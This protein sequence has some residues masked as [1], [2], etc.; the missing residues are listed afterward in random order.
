VSTS[1]SQ[2]AHL[3]FGVFE[4]DLKTGELRRAGVRIKL[5][6]QPFKA[7]ALLAS[8]P[9]EMVSR[10]ELYQHIWGDTIVEEQ[11]LNF[12]IKQIRDALGDD[13]DSPRFI[14]TL[15]KRGYRFLVPVEGLPKSVEA[16][17]PEPAPAH[18]GPRISR[19]AWL[20]GLVVLLAAGLYVVRDRIPGWRGR[21][22]EGKVMLLVLPFDNLSGDPAQEYF[23]DGLT[24]EMI[25]QLGRLNPDRLGVIARNTAMIYKGTKKS[26]AEIGREQEVE[27]ILEGSVRRAGGRVRISAQLIEVRDQTHLWAENYD[28]AVEDVLAIQSDVARHIAGALTLE[29]LPGGDSGLTRPAPLNPAAYDAYLRGRYQWNRRSPEGLQKSIEFYREAIAA[30]PNYPLAYA[31][32][33]DTFGLLGTM[34]YD[35]LPPRDAIPKAEAAA[36]QALAL[37]DSLAEAHVALAHALLYYQWDWPAAEREFQRAFELNAGY[38]TAHQWYSDYLLARGRPDEALAQIQQALKLDP[39]SLVVHLALGRYYYLQRDYDQAIARFQQSIQMD[40]DFF[41]GHFDLGVALVQA[42]RTDEAIA[43]FEQAVRLSGQSPVSLAGLGYAYARAGRAADARKALAQLEVLSRRRHVPPLYFAGIYAGLGENDPA[44]AW[45][46]KAYEAR[47]TYLI[48]IHLEPIFAP[49]HSDP[50]FAALLRRL[51]L[52]Q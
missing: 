15:P 12:C 24:E 41:L 22:A 7:L 51:N 42:G 11:N 5:Q 8:R 27:Y 3:R 44:F 4:L 35:A 29:L 32:L 10:E 52:D 34:P 23:S 33:A 20:A 6:P 37:D 14:E 49:L 47:S 39:Y 16:A 45:L 30:D 18:T 2:S 50:R 43:E 28:R 38:A 17:P 19:A 25:T 46:D 13:A 26:V 1:F 21:P 36:R 48:H 40:P 9:Q 31:G